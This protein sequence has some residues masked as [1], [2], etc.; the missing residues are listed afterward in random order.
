MII[1][2]SIHDPSRTPVRKQGPMSNSAQQAGEIAM[3][4]ASFKPTTR[5]FPDTPRISAQNTD[6]IQPNL[7]KTG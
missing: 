4:V 1:A 2:K 3:T 5:T 7:S 6:R